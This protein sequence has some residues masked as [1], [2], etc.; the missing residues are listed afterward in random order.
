MRLLCL[1]LVLASQSL[2]G[3][4]GSRVE[5][6]GGTTAALEGRVEG[7][8]QVTGE[9]Y[10]LFNFK[11]GVIRVSYDHINL[12]EYGQKVDRRYALAIVVS[13]LLLLSKKRKHFLTI[14]YTDEDGEQQ[15][16]VFRVDKDDIRPLL[17]SL[18][19]RTGRKIQYQD[20]EAR[21]AG[22]G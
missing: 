12:L 14:G 6:I 19:A 7:N 15:A 3:E 22:K 4:Q 5:Y 13:P 21:K 10:L 16:M 11:K 18:E 1:I 9:D 2:A 8:L 20:E 17:A